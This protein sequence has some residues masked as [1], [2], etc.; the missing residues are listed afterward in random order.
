MPLSEFL[1][2]SLTKQVNLASMDGRA[3]LAALAKPHLQRLREGPLRALILDELARLTRLTR[4]DLER[5]A[6]GAAAPAVAEAS[7]DQV[8]DP[9]TGATRLVKRALQLLLERPDLAERVEQVE[10]LEHADAPGVKLL[11]EAVDFFHAHA[12]ARASHLIEFWREH[13]KKA[14]AVQRLLHEEIPL[15]D[16]ALEQEFMDAIGR[17]GDRAL[18]SRVQHLLAEARLRALSPAE[19]REIENLTRRLNAGE[20]KPSRPPS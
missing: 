6:Q 9:G 14:E 13:P 19:T 20:K 11:I 4:A 1:I 12:G 5:L 8:R 18:K 3:K 17:L 7:T 10:L 15:V 16:S 2:S